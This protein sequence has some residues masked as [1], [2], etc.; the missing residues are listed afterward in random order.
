MQAKNLSVISKSNFCSFQTKCALPAVRDDWSKMRQLVLG[1]LKGDKGICLCGDGHIDS[2]DHS[3]R[4]SLYTLMEHITEVV[5]DLKVS[6]KKET[7]DN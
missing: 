2:A 1:V 4:Y 6:N 7:G 5:V 3:A